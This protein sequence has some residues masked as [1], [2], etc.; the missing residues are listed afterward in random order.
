MQQT[1]F[2]LVSAIFLLALR[3]LFLR[4][5]TIRCTALLLTKQ[6]AFLHEHDM[7]R[8]E[9]RHRFQESDERIAIQVVGRFFKGVT[10]SLARREK[11]LQDRRLR[12]LDI[13]M[14]FARQQVNVLRRLL[15]K[16]C[17]E[18]PVLQHLTPSRKNGSY[19][20]LP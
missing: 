5:L 11:T 13:V 20:A 8:H 15:A 6:R 19:G 10:H 7:L 2:L 4:F 3:R 17:H 14:L 1:L 18:R 16:R 9:K 12:F